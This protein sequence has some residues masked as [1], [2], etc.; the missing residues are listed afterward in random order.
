MLD[1]SQSVL[2]VYHSVSFQTGMECKLSPSRTHYTDQTEEHLDYLEQLVPS[3]IKTVTIRSRRYIKLTRNI[4]AKFVTKR[5]E[6]EQN[7][8]RV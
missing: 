7:E 3:W 8:L 2:P 5:L 1:L 4:D 6:D